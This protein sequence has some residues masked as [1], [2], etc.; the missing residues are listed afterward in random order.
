MRSSEVIDR[1][2]SVLVFMFLPGRNN[3]LDKVRTGN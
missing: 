2:H 1:T 3:A